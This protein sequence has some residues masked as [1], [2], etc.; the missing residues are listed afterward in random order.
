MNESDWEQVLR[1]CNL[2]MMIW[3]L[4]YFATLY[5][6]TPMKVGWV[7]IPLL[8]SILSTMKLIE[9]ALH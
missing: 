4:I 9:K 1:L 7:I 3:I 8:G 5:S 2:A 6:P